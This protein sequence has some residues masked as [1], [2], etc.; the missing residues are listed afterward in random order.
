MIVALNLKQIYHKEK[1]RE[2]SNK[3]KYLQVKFH[4]LLLDMSMHIFLLRCNL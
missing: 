2:K 3:L 1:E 4:N